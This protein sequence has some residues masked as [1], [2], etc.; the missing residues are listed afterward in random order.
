MGLCGEIAHRRLTKLE[1]NATYR[2][3]I[4]DAMY[5]LTPD[6]LKEGAR[7]EVR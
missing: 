3:Y 4:I 5:R 1:G 2:N 6:V 7:Y